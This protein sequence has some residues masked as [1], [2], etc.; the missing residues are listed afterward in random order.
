M[1]RL[2]IGKPRKDLDSATCLILTGGSGAYSRQPMRGSLSWIRD[3]AHMQCLVR[4]HGELGFLGGLRLRFR[5]LHCILEIPLR[6][7]ASPFFGI[8]LCYDPQLLSSEHT[9][10]D[11]PDGYNPLYLSLFSIGLRGQPT[12]PLF[13]YFRII[14]PVGDWLTFQKSPSPGIPPIFDNSMTNILD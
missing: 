6:F 5:W 14:G 11:T 3:H 2:F 10:L 7:V 12:L 8:T 9:S 13:K 4:L 1:R